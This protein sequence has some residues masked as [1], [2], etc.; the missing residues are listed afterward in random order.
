MKPISLKSER[1]IRGGSIANNVYHL[2]TKL[3]I[4]LNLFHE[5]YSD[6][7]FRLVRGKKK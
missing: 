7:G 4:T 5:V 6:T 3:N 2:K 1:V